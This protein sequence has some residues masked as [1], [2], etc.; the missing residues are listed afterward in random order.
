MRKIGIVLAFLFAIFVFVSTAI[1]Q[2]E[3]KPEPAIDKKPI[4]AKKIGPTKKI[5]GSVAAVDKNKIT[6]MTANGPMVILADEK[7]TTI[8]YE[9]RDFQL[10]DLTLKSLIT[11]AHELD[12]TKPLQIAKSI[13]IKHLVIEEKK[14]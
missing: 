13:E 2:A 1:A 8:T 6:I 14:K 12:T 11:A 5:T 7:A 9:G 10:K 3:K 4:E